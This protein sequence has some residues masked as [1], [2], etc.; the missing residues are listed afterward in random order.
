MTDQQDDEPTEPPPAPD[1]SL[2]DLVHGSLQWR[3][4]IATLAYRF[5]SLIHSE[6]IAGLI[7]HPRDAGTAVP[8]PVAYFQLYLQKRGLKSGDMGDMARILRG[9]ERSGHLLPCGW[10]TDIPTAPMMGQAYITQGDNRE[11]RYPGGAL[12]LSEVL[13]PELIIESFKPITVQ[14]SGGEGGD[15]GTGLILD[16]THIVTNRHVVEGL[17]AG[18]RGSAVEFEVH[19]SYKPLGGE[20]IQGRSLVKA[21]PDVDVAVIEVALPENVIGFPHL[22]DVV[23]RDPRWHD[24]LRVFG[25][26]RVLGVTEQPITVERGGVVTQSAEAPAING[27]PR[28]KVFLTSAIERPGNS[29]GPIVAQDGRVVGLVIDHIRGGVSQA[30]AGPVEHRGRHSANDEETVDP[31]TSKTPDRSA[32]TPPFYRG[33]PGGEAVRAI[34]ELFPGLARLDDSYAAGEPT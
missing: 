1:T 22:P 32:E 15:S 28:H 16:A 33:I 4:V 26:P 24:D 3:I 13:G 14:I 25:Y 10:R 23:F 31:G 8:W 21:H 18:S 34:N 19:P 30:S 5:F 17:A 12:W 7:N 9:L 2:A 11:H 27:Y 29:G 6:E 20:W